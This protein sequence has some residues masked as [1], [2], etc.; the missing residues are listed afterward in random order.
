MGYSLIS[1]LSQ[2]KRDLM[3]GTRF[4]RFSVFSTDATVPDI[5]EGIGSV[6]GGQEKLSK[7][8]FKGMTKTVNY[9]TNS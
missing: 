5:S 8:I 3:H 9:S 7:G 2:C 1:Q 4:Q 6:Y